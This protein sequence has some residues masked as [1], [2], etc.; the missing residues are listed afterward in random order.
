MLQ[1]KVLVI[2]DNPENMALLVYLLRS[3]GHT[4]FQ[5]VDGAAGLEAADREAPDLVLCDVRMPGLDGYEVAKRLRSDAS[6]R[7]VPLVAVS[8][9][10]FRC[11]SGQ[12][13]GGG[14]RRL[15]L[16]AHRAGAIPGTDP[17]FSPAS[18]GEP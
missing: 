10:V 3:A 4:V 8:A 9:S 7:E 14:V 18:T 16:Q 11:G 2:E 12:G 6:L 15:R 17:G 13:P 1:A 5:A